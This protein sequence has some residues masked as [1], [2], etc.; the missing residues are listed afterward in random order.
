MI[1]RENTIL[2]LWMPVYTHL[3][4]SLKCLILALF[5]ILILIIIYQIFNIT[6][7][8]Q[9]IIAFPKLTRKV[10]SFD[11]AFIS[12]SEDRITELEQILMRTC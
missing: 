5:N 10:K 3:T 6:Q 7:V 1:L 11:F 12:A 8:S 9:M 2:A 4:C